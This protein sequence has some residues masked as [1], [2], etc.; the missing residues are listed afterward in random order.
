MQANNLQFQIVQGTEFAMLFQ[1]C[2]DSLGKEPI[3]LAGYD[4]KGA[5]A[6]PVGP[7]IEMGIAVVDAELGK[8][9]VSLPSGV[10]GT[11]TPGVPLAWDVLWRAAA[12]DIMPLMRGAFS[13]VGK[14]T[15]WT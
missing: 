3:N 14:V 8:I 2:S 6:R 4:F 15:P 9:R 1:L 10:T 7:P 11:L 12:G 5:V 13:V